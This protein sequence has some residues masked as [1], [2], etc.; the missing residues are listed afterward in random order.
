MITAKVCVIM[1]ERSSKIMLD[2]VSFMLEDAV[3]LHSDAHI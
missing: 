1:R 2:I 3:C